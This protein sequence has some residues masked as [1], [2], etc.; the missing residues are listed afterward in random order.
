MKGDHKGRP[1]YTR[2][3]ATPGKYSRDDPLWSPVG[4]LFFSARSLTLTQ[5]MLVGSLFPCSANS[6]ELIL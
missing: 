4:N 2:M 3:H 5:P 6:V 1:Y